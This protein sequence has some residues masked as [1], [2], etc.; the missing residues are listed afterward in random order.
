MGIQHRN[1][2]PLK[3]HEIFL[4]SLISL[5][6]VINRTFETFEEKNEIYIFIQ[7]PEHKATNDIYDRVYSMKTTI[8]FY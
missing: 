2:I 1:L 8:F 4:T 6:F 7:N 3:F 5:S